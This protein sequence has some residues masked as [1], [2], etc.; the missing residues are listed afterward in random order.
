MSDTYE[1]TVKSRFDDIIKDGP[2][3]Y[4]GILEITDNMIGWGDADHIM[5]KYIK[6]CPVMSRPYIEVTDNSVFGF[7]DR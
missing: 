4:T 5:I 6:N 3:I 7:R 2:N 1:E